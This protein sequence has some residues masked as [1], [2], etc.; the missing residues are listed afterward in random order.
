MKN[1][2]IVGYK[3]ANLGKKESAALR[4]AAMVPCVMYGAGK[5]IHFAAPMYLFRDVI[6]TPNVY[7]VELNIEGDIHFA[8]LQDVQ[9]HPVSDIILHADFL[10]LVDGKEI[11][12]EVPV[13]FIGTAL[14]VTKGGKLVQKINKIKV[15]GLAENIPD[16]VDVSI[17][18]LDLGKSVKVGQLQVEG[19]KVLNNASLPIA[20]VEIPRAL[21]GQLKG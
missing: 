15:Q 5:Q 17:T 9:F 11:K 21:R 3:R 7:K 2:E 16:F 8:I 10:E 13:R 18:D 4:E 1:T 6:Y 14:G 19:F 20:G 12:V